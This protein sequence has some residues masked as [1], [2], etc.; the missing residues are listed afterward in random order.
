M[1][2]QPHLYK[3]KILKHCGFIY[4]LM[5]VSL[6]NFLSERYHVTHQLCDLEQASYLP[7]ASGCPFSLISEREIVMVNAF[8]DFV[9]MYKLI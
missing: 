3:N 6:S 2:I 7:C 5:C 8:W 4:L 9:K 1:M